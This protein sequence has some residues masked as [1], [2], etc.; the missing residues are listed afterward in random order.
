MLGEI[1]E[2]LGGLTVTV[3]SILFEFMSRPPKVIMSS[4][5]CFLKAVWV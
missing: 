2:K 3:G 5:F 1:I 4:N